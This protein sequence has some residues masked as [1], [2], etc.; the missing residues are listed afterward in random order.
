MD[1][2][3]P[4]TRTPALRRGERMRYVPNHRSFGA[5]IKSDQMRDVTEEV[6]TD[7]AAMAA[8]KV[9]KAAKNEPS[10]LFDR[11]RAGFKVKRNAGLLRI[12]GNLRVKVEVVNTVAGSALVEH[13]ARNIR[14]RRML[15]EAGGRF[16]DFHPGAMK[17]WGK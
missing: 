10:D 13:G 3:H 15:G 11:V 5:F 8:T 6:A 9:G 2:E 17:K 1:I 14:R 16:G 7:I 12:G 4:E